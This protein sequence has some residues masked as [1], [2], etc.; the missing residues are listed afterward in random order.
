MI[1][2]RY[3]EPGTRSKKATSYRRDGWLLGSVRQP[4]EDSLYYTKVQHT[5]KLSLFI[6]A[7]AENHLCISAQ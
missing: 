3:E 6:I 2:A 1:V 7:V 5:S 4:Q